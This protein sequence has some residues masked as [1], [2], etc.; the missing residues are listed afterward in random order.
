[1][2]GPAKKKGSH[3]KDP[4]QQKKETKRNARVS[5]E[6]QAT[7]ETSKGERRADADKS[8]VRRCQVGEKGGK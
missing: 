7:G 3:H 6:R 2:E 8:Y 5:Q 1:M 4:K